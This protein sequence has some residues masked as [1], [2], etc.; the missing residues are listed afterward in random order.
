MRGKSRSPSLTDSFA[1]FWSFRKGPA[2]G[3]YATSHDKGKTFRCSHRGGRGLPKPISFSL[4]E[5]E[6]VFECQRKRGLMALLKRWQK[7]YGGVRLYAHGV[8]R[9]RPLRPA[10]VEQGKAVVL[11]FSRLVCGPCAA[12]VREAPEWKAVRSYP[13]KMLC[14]WAQGSTFAAAHLRPLHRRRDNVSRRC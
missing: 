6:T 13:A 4:A 1:P 8:D 3:I 12:G 7:R 9:P 10:P 2:G 11:S 14:C 5:K